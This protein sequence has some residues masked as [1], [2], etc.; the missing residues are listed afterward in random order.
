M[1]SAPVIVHDLVLN[2]SASIGVTLCPQ[3]DADAEIL[4]RHADQAMYIAKNAGKNCY[5][6][7]DS[8]LDNAVNLEQ[9][10]IK[11]ISAA[12]DKGELVLYYQPKVNMSTCEV[13]GVE[14]LVRWQDPVRGLVPPLDFYL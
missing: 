11:N 8:T 3:D 12:L 5:H 9:E 10:N 7:F 6:L 13:V 2:V 14:A 4:I 1:V